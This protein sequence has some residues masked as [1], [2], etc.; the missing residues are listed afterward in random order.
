MMS[1]SSSAVEDLTE[2]EE[3]E[4]DLTETAEL[5]DVAHPLP[6]WA[7]LTNNGAVRR[8]VVLVLLALL[9]QGSAARSDNPLMLPSFS[10]TIRAWWQVTLSGELPARA[11][12]SMQ[13]LLI[14]YSA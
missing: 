5:G 10:D 7:R 2:F 9:W 6:L 13:V 8:A 3:Y 4:V 1:T 14:G 11:G 12:A